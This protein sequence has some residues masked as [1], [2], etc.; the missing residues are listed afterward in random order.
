MSDKKNQKKRRV[1]IFPYLFFGTIV[2]Y[3]LIHFAPI[4]MSSAA[5]TEV[6]KYDSIQIIHQM[7]CYII[8]N[9]K[10]IKSNQEGEIKYFAQEGERVKKG[11]K[12][13]EIYKDAVDDATRKKLEVVNQRIENLNE[14]KEN[15]FERDVEKLDTEIHKTI[16]QLK[17]YN[18]KGNLLKVEELKKELTSKLDK[19]RIIAGDKSFAGKNLEA[20][21]QEQ[22]QLEKKINNS[23]SW[24][25]SPEPG[26]V[27]YQIDG[28][29]SILNPSNMAALEY[30]KISKIEPQITDLR[31][32]KVIRTQP[33]FK[34]VD[35]NIWYMV[36][37]LDKGLLD[38]YKVGR[39]VEFKFPQGQIKGQ[40]F[41]VIEND[42]NIAVI[43]KID[44]Y[45]EGFYKTRNIDLEAVVLNYEGLKVPKESILEKDGKKGVL[46]LDINRNATF[47][48]VKV[49]GYDEVSAIVH[50]NVFYEIEG[51]QQKAVDTI[52]LYDEIVKNP[53]RVKEGQMIY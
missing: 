41:R 25:L 47:K 13:A 40:I 6:V 43:F 28:Y 8:R 20:L 9:E 22:Q 21:K 36:T 52:K 32:Q 4:V 29:E 23:I 50:S 31:V 7:T 44:E 46:V 48:P 11:Y 39:T 16:S 26:I 27:S 1:G 2:L 18:E 12:I 45:I 19:K 38:Q 51:D 15:L 17:E 37:W 10:L 3:L 33:L 30:E 5:E 14:N 42:K 35:N 53:S 24:M 34:I 49:K